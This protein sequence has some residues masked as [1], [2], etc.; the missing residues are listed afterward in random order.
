MR[1]V[2]PG[3]IGSADAT[4]ASNWSAWIFGPALGHPAT[5]TPSCTYPI[6]ALAAQFSPPRFHFEFSVPLRPR[7]LVLSR[8]GDSWTSRLAIPLVF[9]PITLRYDPPRSLRPTLTRPSAFTG[10][11][12]AR[13]TCRP[14]DVST[15]ADPTFGTV[16]PRHSRRP[17]AR[18]L[19]P[20]RAPLSLRAHRIGRISDPRLPTAAHRTAACRQPHTT[21]I[22]SPNLSRHVPRPCYR[23]L[24]VSDAILVPTA[25]RVHKIPRTRPSLSSSCPRAIRCAAPSHRLSFYLPFCSVPVLDPTRMTSTTPPL[26]VRHPTLP[27]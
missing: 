9:R 26:F 10:T 12:A 20:S 7:H 25:P 21:Y 18:L 11:D 22:D 23:S 4:W 15:T 6:I 1:V 14:L 13:P 8:T 19:T 24:C 2:S 16:H 5:P 27:R 17:H 3:Q